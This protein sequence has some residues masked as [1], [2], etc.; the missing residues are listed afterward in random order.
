MTRCM[1]VRRFLVFFGFEDEFGAVVL[2]TEEDGTAREFDEEAAD[3]FS[4]SSDLLSDS[5]VDGGL[6]LCTCAVSLSV[7]TP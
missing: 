3:L 6:A 4:A 2:E 7:C 1:V 5:T